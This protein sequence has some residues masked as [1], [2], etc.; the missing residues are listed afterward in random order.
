MMIIGIDLGTTNSLIAVWEDGR[1]LLIPNAQGSFLT[2]SVISLDPSGN[3]VVG[4][5]AIEQLDAHNQ[6]SLASFKRYMGT[7]KVLELGTHRFR[8]EELSALV[9][10]SLIRDAETYLGAKVT[11]AV[12]TV[13]AYFNDTQRKATRLAG[14]LAGLKVERLLNEP[15]AAALAYGLHNREAESKFLIFDLGGGTFDVS[16]VELFSGV[17]EVRS[18]A[19]DNRLGGEDFT[20]ALEDYLKYELLRR[21]QLDY[22][23]LDAKQKALMRRAAQAVVHQL[24]GK[25]EA[26]F[27]FNGL[28]IGVTVDKFNELVQPLMERIKIPLEKALRDARIMPDELDLVILVG[29]ATRMPIIGREVAKMFGKFPQLILHPDEAVAMGAAVQAALKSQHRDLED[30][31]ITDVCPYSLGTDVLAYRHRKGGGV[32]FLPIIERNTTIPASRAERL[33]TTEDNQTSVNISVFQGESYNVDE[34]VKIGEVLVTLPRAR[35][36]EEPFE[37]R[38]TYDIN[39]LL[40]VEVTV[41]SSGKKTTATF[42]NQQHALTGDEIRASLQK[43][44]ELKIHPRDQL[45]NRKMIADLEKLYALLKGDEREILANWIGR[46]HYA[47]DSEDPEDIGEVYEGAKA[48]LDSFQRIF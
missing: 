8:P 36:G 5:P 45:Q 7:G 24:S 11:E 42:S 25:D 38:Y 22:N 41:L 15:T 20:D 13:P 26:V 48:L 23:G 40:E 3:I 46:F 44:Q 28:E 12:I 10:K 2:P 30:V 17:I 39:G 29:G 18:S 47:L 16:I 14:E 19:G 33:Y 35:A 6:L 31:V 27:Q 21:H 37:V 34:N 43:L 9:L 32:K 4:N 1:S